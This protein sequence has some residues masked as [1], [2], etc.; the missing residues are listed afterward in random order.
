MVEELQGVELAQ[1]PEVGLVTGEKIRIRVIP[2]KKTPKV[3]ARG[4]QMTMIKPPAPPPPLVAPGQT[5]ACPLM[6][7]PQ[8]SKAKVTGNLM[9][10]N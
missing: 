1:E 10:Y 7:A 5:L 9:S 4:K 2:V 6:V 8:K 3:L